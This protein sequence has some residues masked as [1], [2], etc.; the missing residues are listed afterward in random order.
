MIIIQQIIKKEKEN[1]PDIL[2]LNDW[3]FN[4]HKEYFGATKYLSNPYDTWVS[5]WRDQG[6]PDISGEGVEIPTPEEKEE[7]D[8]F[9]EIYD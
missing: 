8:D 2:D 7:E 9:G 5:Y 3:L 6:C 1:L 4:N